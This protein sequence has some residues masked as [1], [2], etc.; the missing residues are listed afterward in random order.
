M[1]ISLECRVFSFGKHFSTFQSILTLINR[2]K[3]KKIEERIY[4][5]ITYGIYTANDKYFN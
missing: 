3:K 4:K 2:K 1:R 5:L